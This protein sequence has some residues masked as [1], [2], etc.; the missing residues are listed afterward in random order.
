MNRGSIQERRN[1][2]WR[3]CPRSGNKNREDGYQ[4][5]VIERRDQF[6]L[7]SLGCNKLQRCQMTVG[8]KSQ[9]TEAANATR[10]EI[11]TNIYKLCEMSRYIDTIQLFKSNIDL[12]KFIDKFLC[13]I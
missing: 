11:K 3:V 1:G 4:I 9:I 13:V 10:N 6:A 2:Q 7:K 8:K 5:D 12:M